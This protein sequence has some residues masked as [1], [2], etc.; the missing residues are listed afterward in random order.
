MV[1]RSGQNKCPLSQ[2]HWFATKFVAVGKI[3]K[4]LRLFFVV[5]LL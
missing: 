3:I 1:M 2:G 5:S 4:N